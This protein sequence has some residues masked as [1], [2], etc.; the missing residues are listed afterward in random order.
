MCPHIE[1]VQDPSGIA[2]DRCD[3][4]ETTR[5]RPRRQARAPRMHRCVRRRSSTTR[6]AVTLAASA[7]PTAARRRQKTLLIN[8]G[9]RTPRDAR[10]FSPG[11]QA[12]RRR[13]WAPCLH[14]C[15]H[16]GPDTGVDCPNTTGTAT[17]KP[18]PPS[19]RVFM[20]IN[21]RPT[22]SRAGRVMPESPGWAH[23]PDRGRRSAARYSAAPTSHPIPAS[24]AR[25]RRQPPRQNRFTV[26]SGLYA[27]KPSANRGWSSPR[28][29]RISRLSA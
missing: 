11:G 13:R 6:R 8:G 3:A 24:I 26:Y 25:I 21:R 12:G 18:R 14:C 1:L 16:L 23:K 2:C 27:H 17:P 4:T 7:F 15:T 9:A 19:I 22:A 20:R 28:D 10:I 5:N 29:A